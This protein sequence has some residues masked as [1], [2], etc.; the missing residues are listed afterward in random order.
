MA[1]KT[2]GND[3]LHISNEMAQ[4]DNKNYD[5][6]DSLTDEEKKKISLY[7]FIR[8]GATITGS[9]DFQSYYLMSVNQNL[10]VNFFNI[11]KHPKLQWLC[12]AASSPGMGNQRHYWLTGAKKSKVSK[13]KNQLLEMMPDTKES[14]IDLILQ[15]NSESEI[16]DWLRKTG[17]SEKELDQLVK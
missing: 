12:C 2:V 7:I 17:M 8:W 14:D 11:A 9:I 16:L 4:F 13:I 15:V 3:I 5:F 1:K 6:Y 10:N